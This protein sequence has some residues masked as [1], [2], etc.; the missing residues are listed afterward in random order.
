MGLSP[1]IA[2]VLFDYLSTFRNSKEVDWGIAE[3]DAVVDRIEI[4]GSHWLVL[5][6]FGDHALHHFF[7][8]LDHGHL[9]LLYPILQE[10]MKEFTVN[11]RFASQLTLVKGQFRQLIKDEPNPNPPDLF[12]ELK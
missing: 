12:K 8:T 7:P 9:E 6:N 3:L 2:K 4:T 10:T 5:T 1:N 11:L